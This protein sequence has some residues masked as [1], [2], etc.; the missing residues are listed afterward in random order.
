MGWPTGRWIRK[1][2]LDTIQVIQQITEIQHM[3]SFVSTGTHCV[4]R[5]RGGREG[6]DKWG[7]MVEGKVLHRYEA[8]LVSDLVFQASGR[9]RQEGNEGAIFFG[10]Q[11]GKGHSCLLWFQRNSQGH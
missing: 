7:E 8:V 5:L 6:K 2:H 10:P 1:C 4:N 11:E 9:E 3:L